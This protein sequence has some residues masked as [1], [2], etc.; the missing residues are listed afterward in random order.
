MNKF[1]KEMLIGALLG[2]A[3][4]G[5]TGADKAFISFEQA[6][7]KSEYLHYLHKLVSD[8]GF[9][10]EAPKEYERNDPRYPNRVTKSLY[11]RT[12]SLTELRPLA[13]LFLDNE[14]KK[15]VPKNIAEMLTPRSL[16]FWIMDD[17]Q[18]V[19]RGGVTLCTDSFNKEEISIL[20]EALKNQFNLATTIH[21]KSSKNGDSI[22]ERIYINKS[23]LEE[24]KSTLKEHM[25]DTMLYKINDIPTETKD[26][27]R[28]NM[29]MK[30]L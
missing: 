30:I 16:A 4:I 12:E 18:Q 6:K 3:H 17:G 10:V 7:K 9:E 11:F 15:V 2:D 24:I 1:I 13:D 22:Y 23:S 20:R 5:K 29:I 27:D 26:D 28:L 19:K 21:N 8:E 14:N 25:H